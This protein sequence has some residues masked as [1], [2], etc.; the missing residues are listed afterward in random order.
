MG[1]PAPRS[2]VPG[3]HGW[4]IAFTQLSRD[5]APQV[6]A[7]VQG[8]TLRFRAIGLHSEMQLKQT[9]RGLS[10]FLAVMGQRGLLFIVDVTLIDGMAVAGLAGAAL[11]VRLID[12]HGDTVAHC[13][14]TPESGPLHYQT[15]ADEIGTAAGLFRSAT[16]VYVMA[17]AH[18]DLVSMAGHRVGT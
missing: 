5:V 18:F 13:S 16:S 17:M 8:L 7:F 6:E 14:A 10:T 11:D 4:D 2:V 12:A 3:D 1:Q 9:P 15:N